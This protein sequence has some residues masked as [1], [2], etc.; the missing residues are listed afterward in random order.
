MRKAIILLAVLLVIPFSGITEA[1]L[2]IVRLTFAGDTTLGGHE[3]WMNHASGTFKVMARQQPPEYF[4]RH[5]KPIFERDDFTLLNL[6]GVLADSPRG[7][8]K[9]AKWNFRGETAYTGILTAGSVEGVTLGNNHTGDFGQPGLVSTKAALD[10]AGIG[11]C[12]DRDALIFEKDGVRIAFLGFWSASFDKHREWL[13]AEIPRLK[14]DG[15]C[16][17][18]VVSYHGGRQYWPFHRDSQAEDMRYAVD[19]GA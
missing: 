16:D 9:A 3:G 17:A 18:V 15:G 7:L 14:A 13:Q 1:E 5:A 10:A 2:R 19:C 12:L 8:N 6:E 4:L 11:W